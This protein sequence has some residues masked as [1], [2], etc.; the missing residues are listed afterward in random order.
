MASY[1]LAGL[2]HPTCSGLCPAPTPISAVLCPSHSPLHVSATLS[3]PSHPNPFTH[4]QEEEFLKRYIEYCRQNC[5]PR[6]TDAA[7]QTLAS[8]YVE[9]RAEVRSTC[10]F[11]YGV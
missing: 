6:L 3:S 9:L 5:S 7:A 1:A 2:S 4:L 8:E 10:C 11:F